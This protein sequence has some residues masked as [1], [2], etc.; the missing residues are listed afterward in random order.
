MA[1]ELFLEITQKGSGYDFTPVANLA[2]S[3]EGGAGKRAPPLRASVSDAG[4]VTKVEADICQPSEGDTLIIKKACVG[5]RTYG[6]AGSFQ[7]E[8]SPQSPGPAPAACCP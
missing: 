5:T 1:G 8:S 3:W 2:G 6:R 4:E 7:R